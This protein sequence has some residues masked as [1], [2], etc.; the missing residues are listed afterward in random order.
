MGEVPGAA[1]EILTA[2]IDRLLDHLRVR[3][4]E[5]RGSERVDHVPRGQPGAAL[6]TPADVGVGDQTVDRLA[7]RKVALEDAAKQPTLS[8]GR[9]GEAPVA[10]RRCDLRAAP[11]DSAQL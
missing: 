10:P 2:G 8:P 1:N 4:G 6:R 11:G 9:V 7:D 3:P 5:V